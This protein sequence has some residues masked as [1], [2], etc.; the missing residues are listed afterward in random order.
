M[1]KAPPF[2][3][4][5]YFGLVHLFPSCT[6]LQLLVGFGKASNCPENPIHPTQLHELNP[7]RVTQSRVAWWFP[8]DQAVWC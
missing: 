2:A 8:M 5:F 3:R 7:V 1:I 4:G 6:K